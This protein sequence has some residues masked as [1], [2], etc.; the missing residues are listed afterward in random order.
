MR[1]QRSPKIADVT[2]YHHPSKVS[3][4]GNP[5][6]R[7]FDTPEPTTPTPTT[8]PP[9][10]IVIIGGGFVAAVGIVFLIRRIR[11]RT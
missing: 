9:I 1:I 6:L 11:L 3:L 8:P 4:F 7:V 5:S 10:Y 2:S